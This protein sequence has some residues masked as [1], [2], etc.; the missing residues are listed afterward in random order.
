M[1]SHTE[2]WLHILYV[3]I[4]GR[5]GL[6]KT[7]RPKHFPCEKLGV[8]QH[9]PPKLDIVT[10]DWPLPFTAGIHELRQF[11]KRFFCTFRTDAA[12]SRLCLTVVAE[13]AHLA[14]I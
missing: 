12:L 9:K 7:V 14:G 5:I 8:S 3:L 4:D 11:E 10:I 13:A 2:R 1:P 6:A